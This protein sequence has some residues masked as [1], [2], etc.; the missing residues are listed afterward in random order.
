M[1]A[2]L[3]SYVRCVNR[4]TYLMHVCYSDVANLIKVPSPNYSF[5]GHKNLN[6]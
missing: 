5:N 3:V 6:N 4:F 1:H 2:L